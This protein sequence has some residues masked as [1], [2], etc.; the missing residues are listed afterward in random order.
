MGST[1]ERR[2][3][4]NCS[5]LQQFAM[6][7]TPLKEPLSYLLSSAPG[8]GLFSWWRP[9]LHLQPWHCHCNSSS[10]SQHCHGSAIVCEKHT[11]PSGPTEFM[12]QSTVEMIFFL[13][14]FLSVPH[15]WR[16]NDSLSLLKVIFVSWSLMWAVDH[17]CAV[18]VWQFLSLQSRFLCLDYSPEIA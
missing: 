9:V 6:S 3:K 4:G 13:F 15:R 17:D 16:C 18:S 1:A 14:P 2:T 10:L 11:I 5:A 8:G 7:P 12:K